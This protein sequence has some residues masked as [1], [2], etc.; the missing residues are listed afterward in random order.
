[1]ADQ[2]K[3]DDFVTMTKKKLLNSTDLFIDSNEKYT[4][5]QKERYKKKVGEALILA[6]KIHKDQRPRP[7]G[8]Y[9]NHILRV[10]NRIVEEYGIKD[11]EL[12][13]AALLHDSVEDQAKK[14]AQFVPNVELITERK[15]ALLFVKNTFGERV[16][17]IVSKL[18]NPEQETEGLSSEQENSIYKEH[19][20]KAIEDADV[21]PIKLSDFSDNALNLEAVDDRLR[22]LKLS[23]K[24]L[25]VMEVFIERLKIAQNVLAEEKI[26]EMTNRLLLV[27]EN[28][29]RFIKDEEAI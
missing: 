10:S 18:S 3:E 26:T 12:V 7:D 6:L 13:M 5:S 22:R 11:P 24:Y 21:L 8:P 14:L 23:K 4:S 25:P 2:N 15:K 27:M 29:N 16:S 20:R 9:V 28:T 1:M 17:K 19:V